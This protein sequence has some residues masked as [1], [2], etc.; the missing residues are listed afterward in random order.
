M[1]NQATDGDSVNAEIFMLCFS[2]NEPNEDGWLVVKAC[3]VLRVQTQVK[4]GTR[5]LYYCIVKLLL[6]ARETQ[7]K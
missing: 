2:E 1:V 6:C 3:Y 4:P 7:R 5:I